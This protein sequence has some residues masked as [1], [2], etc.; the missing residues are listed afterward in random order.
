MSEAGQRTGVFAIAARNR[1]L[2]RLGVAFALF[3]GAEV[4][5]WISL[6][7]YAYNEGGATAA[8]VM[9]LV[10]VVPSIV[11][12]PWIG[13]WADR[14]RPGRVLLAGYVAQAAMMALAA[15]LIAAGGPFGAILLAAPLINLAVCATRPAQGALLP[16]VVASPEELAAA[17]AGENWLESAGTIAGPVAAGVLLAA[18]GAELALAGMALVALAAAVLV[19]GLSGP[20]PFADDDQPEG[21][22]AQTLAGVR[23][24]VADPPTRT[25]VGLLGAQYVLLGAMDLLYVV[26]A[27]DVL[28][29]G[30]AGAGYLTAAFGLGGL[31][32]IA[33][34]A[35]L[36]GRRRLAPALFAGG[37]LACGTLLIIAAWPSRTIAFLLIGL[38]GA[39]RAVFDVTGRTLL[40]R[41]ASPAAL[42]AAFGLLE[43]LLNAGLALGS[44]IVPLLVAAGGPT[45]ALA[46]TGAMMLAG[47]LLAL[48]RLRSIDASAVVQIVEINLLRGIRLFAA[49]PAPALESL[50]RGLQRVPAAAGDVIIRQGEH[51]DRYYAIARGELDVAIDGAHVRTCTAP[52]GVGELALLHDTLRT[53]TVTA[54]TDADL[55]ALDRE[56]FLQALTGHVSHRYAEWAPD[57]QPAAEVT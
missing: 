23:T 41:T 2:L 32:A 14:L 16:S 18:G 35:S 54:R 20:P 22:V 53:A 3:N 47:L 57:A 19:L 40:Q 8:S 11:A 21:S 52:E 30:D 17:N 45:A 34:T 51:G 24:I 33:V 36:V 37:A 7:V 44:L 27:I 39:G 38:S 9:A 12:A 55:Y 43:A 50:A 5:V 49:L 56:P 10:Q 46:G 31:A 29:L 1:R 28:D 13:S 15:A 42:A 26:L 4:G 25:L 6:L 48:P